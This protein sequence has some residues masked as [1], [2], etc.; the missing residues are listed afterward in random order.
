H[1]A[2]AEETRRILD[3]DE[4]EPLIVFVHPGIEDARDG[5]R[6]H[7]RTDAD[8]RDRALREQQHDSAADAGAERIRR[9]LAEHDAVRAGLERLQAA[10]GHEIGEPGYLRL[11]LRIDA[12][13]HE[14]DGR[15]AG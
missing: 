11:E 4:R 9:A 1:A 13:D 12:A 8:R 2:G 10:R 6:A 5:E 3:V 14:P 7:P 15:A